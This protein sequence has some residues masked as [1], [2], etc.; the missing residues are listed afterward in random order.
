M[1]YKLCN[2]IARNITYPLKFD[3]CLLSCVWDSMLTLGEPALMLVP[4]YPPPFSKKIPNTM[5]QN[6]MIWAGRGLTKLGV[7]KSNLAFSGLNM[8]T[9][10]LR[11]KL[12]N[13]QRG[14]GSP[15]KQGLGSW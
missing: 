5:P 3:E 2:K 10:R 1:L 14:G 12:S 11:S 15:C 6:I 9:K 4:W 8:V 7:F 13:Y